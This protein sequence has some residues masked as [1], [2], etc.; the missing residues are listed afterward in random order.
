MAKAMGSVELLH[1]RQI[2]IAM[3]LQN[4]TFKEIGAQVGVTSA[5][6]RQIWLRAYKKS[7]GTLATEATREELKLLLKLKPF[8]EGIAN[9]N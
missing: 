8:L 9:G 7:N 2:V 6:V 1:R 4:K 3:R 5:R